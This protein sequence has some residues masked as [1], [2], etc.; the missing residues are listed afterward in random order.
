MDSCC[1][2]IGQAV[3][4]CMCAP[5]FKFVLFLAKP[6][7]PRLFY[8]CFIPG[9][10][11]TFALERWHI[12]LIF[13]GFPIDQG[14]YEVYISERKQWFAQICRQI[15]Y[16]R[17]KRSEKNLGGYRL[18]LREKTLLPVDVRHSKLSSLIYHFHRDNHA[19]CLHPPPPSPLPPQEN[20]LTIVSNFSWALQSSQEKSKT[21][22]MQN[23]GSKQ[24]ALWFMWKWWIS[25][26]FLSSF[27]FHFFPP[28][29]LLLISIV[30]FPPPPPLPRS[31]HS[32]CFPSSFVL[33]RVTLSG[34]KFRHLEFKWI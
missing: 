30:F 18:I 26:F 14:R 2:L 23:C 17:K 8:Y 34:L 13:E 5:C 19:P 27:S 33:D 4:W 31:P 9:S 7:S 12:Y 16:I 28:S 15:V 32:Y 21:I 22:V 3:G 29:L 1:A 24:V 6:F 25:I 11:S 20:Y 10:V